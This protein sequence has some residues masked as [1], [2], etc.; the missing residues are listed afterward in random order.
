[1]ANEL[2][3][4]TP[5]LLL[6]HILHSMPFRLLR[7]GVITLFLLGILWLVGQW[8]NAQEQQQNHIVKAM[9]SSW[10]EQ[11]TLTGPLLIVPF[12][13]HIKR[14]DTVTDAAGEK[15]VVSND[16]FN[17]HI[18]VLLPTDL[19][20]RTDIKQEKRQQGQ[21]TAPVY[22]ANISLT[23]NFDHS[24][25]TNDDTAGERRILW[26]KASLVLGLSD[27]K[28]IDMALV[29]FWDN[30]RL[31]VEPGTQNLTFMPTGFHAAL[32]AKV[33]SETTHPFKVNLTLRGSDGLYFTP[34]GETTKLRVNATWPQA[35]F[36]GHLLPNK[37][38]MTDQGFIADWQIPHLVRNY[39]QNWELDNKQTY[40]LNSFTVGVNLKTTTSLLTTIRQ[41]LVYGVGLI[42]LTLLTLLLIEWRFAAKA[43]NAIPYILTGISLILFYPLWLA[44]AAFINTD[45]AYLGAAG[46]VIILITIYTHSL[47]HKVKPTLLIAGILGVLFATLYALIRQETYH[48]PII[49][50]LLLLALGLVMYVTRLPPTPSQQQLVN[51]PEERL[52][53]PV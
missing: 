40:D 44:L 43:F 9:T 13:E 5:I 45:Y 23:G 41:T 34:T 2:T 47:W 4:P 16:T 50:T 29:F 32:P 52:L 15:K 6:R 38:E 27:T 7:L 26:E 8:L 20:I 22:T 42:I 3:T 49:M 28:A 30:E 18:L 53:P 51:F 11:Q 35:D 1:M 24:V 39:P 31:K 25:I 46:G 19:E 17:D 33:S 36:T 37:L 12:V 48:L 21:Y 10:G 14:V